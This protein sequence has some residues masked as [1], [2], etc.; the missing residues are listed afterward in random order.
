M[1]L[2]FIELNYYSFINWEKQ[3]LFLFLSLIIIVSI[4]VFIN[5]FVFVI[6]GKHYAKIEHSVLV[7]FLMG[8]MLGIFAL[9]VSII[10]KKDLV[11]IIILFYTV[12]I[13]STIGLMLGIKAQLEDEEEEKAVN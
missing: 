1:F 6:L 4:S 5:S 10:F 2:S 9:F 8:L 3:L 13:G 7:G 11:G 12:A